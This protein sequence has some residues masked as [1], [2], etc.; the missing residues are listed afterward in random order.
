MWFVFE[1]V[2]E[3]VG[4]FLDFM[5]MVESWGVAVVCGLG[6]IVLECDIFFDYVIDIVVILVWLD[7][8]EVLV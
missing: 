1:V 2:F 8:V 3:E 7:D 4:L 5:I 6:L